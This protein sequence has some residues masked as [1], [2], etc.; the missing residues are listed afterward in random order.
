ME[1]YQVMID[2]DMG[3]LQDKIAQW[4]RIPQSEL[5]KQAVIDMCLSI[6]KQG[7]M[8]PL[9]RDMYQRVLKPTDVYVQPVPEIQYQTEEP[10]TEEE[11]D[12]IQL[13]LRMI[14]VSFHPLIM[15]W[16]TLAFALATCFS[17]I[18]MPVFLKW[19]Q[20]NVCECCWDKLYAMWCHMCRIQIVEETNELIQLIS[21]MC[22]RQKYHY[23]PMIKQC[24][25]KRIN[26]VV[27]IMVLLQL[28]NMMHNEVMFLK[29]KMEKK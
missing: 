18:D 13:T 12:L 6:R 25:L 3:I 10:L 8:T 4:N 19:C 7:R 5:L 11:A 15:T 16:K 22:D 23:K 26:G 24:K 14:P 28:R 2:R 27:D 21:P 20:E 9:V 29:M 1:D 17:S